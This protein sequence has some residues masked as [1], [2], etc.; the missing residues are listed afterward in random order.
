MNF[1]KAQ[2][3]VSV[4]LALLA[5]LVFITSCEVF[6]PEEEIVTPQQI[7][8]EL[9]EGDW[10]ATSYIKEHSSGMPVEYMSDSLLNFKIEFEEYSIDNDR[11]NFEWI[12]TNADGTANT[13][14]GD[15]SCKRS[16]DELVFDFD[17]NPFGLDEEKLGLYLNE[18]ELIL[19]GYLFNAD[20]L[21]KAERD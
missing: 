1:L 2:I 8:V 6:C 20:V 14:K 12:M 9:L 13:F 11:A 7:T 16:G 4:L 19:E 17:F 10:E 21:I 18:D 15:Y 5:T 3:K